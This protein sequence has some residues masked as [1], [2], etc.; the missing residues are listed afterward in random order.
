MFNKI[1]GN[2][3]AKHEGVGPPVGGRS[4]VALAWPLGPSPRRRLCGW[5]DFLKLSLWFEIQ[6]RGVKI[7]TSLGKMNMVIP[8]TLFHPKNS[9][10]ELP[11]RIMEASDTIEMISCSPNCA[12]VKCEPTSSLSN[13]PL[14]I[15]V[16]FI[17]SWIFKSNSKRPLFCFLE[18]V[19]LKST[20]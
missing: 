5:S 11:Q 20:S 3:L 4:A 16:L 1:M 14:T 15:A 13:R 12:F 6:A 8:S 18:K 2:P 7:R 10:V 19:C 9:N 17:K